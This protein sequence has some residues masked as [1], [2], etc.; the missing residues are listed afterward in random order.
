MGKKIVSYF[1]NDLA[2]GGEIWS[3]AMKDYNYP[4]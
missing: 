2:K 3:E 1:R 4:R